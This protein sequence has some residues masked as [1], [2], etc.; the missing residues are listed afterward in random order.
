MHNG[1]K[2]RP[3]A[4]R[5]PLPSA[6]RGGKGV[7]F[8]AWGPA[9]GDAGG[10]A[11][12]GIRVKI[13]GRC[14]IALGARVTRLNVTGIV[15]DGDNEG[16]YVARRYLPS[17]MNLTLITVDF[18][19][20]GYLDVK[21]SQFAVRLAFNGIS[22]GKMPRVVSR[23]RE[24]VLRYFRKAY[25]FSTRRMIFLFRSAKIYSALRNLTSDRQREA[26][27]L[28]RCW[29]H[30]SYLLG[31]FC[32]VYSHTIKPPIMEKRRFVPFPSEEISREQTISRCELH[33][34]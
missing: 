6:G 12:R 14:L 33:Y 9:K 34:T 31:R 30:T 27:H 26:P 22:S 17:H 28:T 2:R 13:R 10:W 11:H 20:A 16:F 25:I 4:V 15:V 21:P 24:D 32:C 18:A 19:R 7:N 8:N 23:V 29:F 1:R 5:L 3:G